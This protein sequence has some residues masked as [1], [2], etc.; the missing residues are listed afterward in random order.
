MEISNI[1]QLRAHIAYFL[2]M[3][4]VSLQNGVLGTTVEMRALNL[5]TDIKNNLI[6]TYFSPSLLNDTSLIQA[7]GIK[8]YILARKS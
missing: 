3:W 7:K 2:I 5:T 4:A 6:Y 1:C 8:T